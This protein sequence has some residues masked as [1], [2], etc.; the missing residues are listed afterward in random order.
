MLPLSIL[1]LPVS[2]QDHVWGP[3]NA[4]VTL[5][6]YGDYQCPRCGLVYPL[7]LNL[8]DRLGDRLCFVFRHFPR[9]ELYPHAQHAAEAAE[10]AASQGR[11]WPMHDCLYTRQQALGN[12]YLV[13]YAAELGL[14]VRQFLREVTGD[15]HV[16][17]VQADIAS[18]RASGVVDT[19]TFFINGQRYRGAHTQGA[20]WEALSSPG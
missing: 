10:A 1:A 19:P 5:V 8:L 20:L 4:A 7:M 2:A 17:R 12:G 3:I 16:E 14:N 9:A 11:F 6:Q 13:E 18:G 15:R